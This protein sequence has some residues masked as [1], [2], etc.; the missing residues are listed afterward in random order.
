VSGLRF[1]IRSGLVLDPAG[2]MLDGDADGAP[3]GDAVRTL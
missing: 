1:S 3:G 2:R